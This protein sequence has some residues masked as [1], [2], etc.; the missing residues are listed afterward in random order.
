MRKVIIITHLIIFLV[1]CTGDGLVSDFSDMFEL[2]DSL[3]TIYPEEEIDVNISNG[4]FIGITFTNS[5]LVQLN[6]EEKNKVA[7][8]I[9]LITRYFFDE[10]RIKEGKLIL[11]VSKDNVLYKSSSSKSYDLWKAEDE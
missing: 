6:E 1:S 7:Q 2:Q 8:N 5:D 4:E 3:S 10:E 11:M 9:G